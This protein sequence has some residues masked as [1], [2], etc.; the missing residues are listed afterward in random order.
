MLDPTL[1]GHRN[2]DWLELAALYVQRWDI[3][4]RMREVK[5]TRGMDHLRVKTLE[6]V[7]KTLRLILIAYN[8]NKSSCQEGSM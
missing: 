8:P 6:T 7:R 1:I 3:E 4:L 2:Y 5:F